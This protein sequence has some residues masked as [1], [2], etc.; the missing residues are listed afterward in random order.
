LWTATGTANQIVF[1]ASNN[2][3]QVGSTFAGALTT[4]DTNTAFADPHGLVQLQTFTLIR[5]LRANHTI[6]FQIGDV[7]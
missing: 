6:S 3:V 1:D 4:A 5:L 2:A 7:N